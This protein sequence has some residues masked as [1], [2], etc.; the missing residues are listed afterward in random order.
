MKLK[1]LSLLV[2]C[3]S[4]FSCS[5]D[6][7]IN[8][9]PV[10]DGG[11]AETVPVERD[12]NTIL[13]GSFNI[14]YYNTADTY[15]WAMRREAV[16]KFV[17]TE[18]PD[19][20]AMQEVC[21]IQGQ[22]IVE[23]IDECF[24][25]YGVGRFG[26]ELPETDD[27]GVFILYRKDRFTLDEGVFILYRKDRFTLKDKGFFWLADPHDKCPELNDDGWSYSSWESRFPRV[28]VWIEAEDTWHPGQTVWFF[29]THYDNVSSYARTRSSSLIVEQIQKLAETGGDLKGAP[30]PV[31][32]TGDFNS[33]FNSSELSA[34][35]LAMYDARTQSPFTE[36]SQNTF[37]N[38]TES[39][40]SI[41]D[42]IFY[43]GNISPEQYDV[44]T[45]DYGVRFISDHW[46]VLFL[47]SYK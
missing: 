37:N 6:P 4:A 17:N 12:E 10:Q 7:V 11:G 33:D 32:L 14:R 25:Y 42:H 31:I 9:L 13:S 16:M 18:K 20:L 3:S 47:C 36:P 40:V 21:R 44:V 45:E 8:R 27:E 38:F 22:Y 34:I 43:G 1:L 35:R 2:I 46:P 23:N 19:F 5:G 29:A 26:G 39:G 15:S 24:G 41:V 28:A 30:M